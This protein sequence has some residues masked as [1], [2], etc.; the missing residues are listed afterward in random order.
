[1]TAHRSSNG[2][3]WRGLPASAQAYVA[4]VIG[5]GALAVAASVPFR[6]DHPILFASLL[7]ASCLTSVWKVN[8][9]IPLASGSTLSVSYAANLTALLLLG[10]QQ[11][12]IIAIVG[13]WVQC[14]FNVKC[15]YPPYR[16]AFSVAAEAITMCLTAAAYAW[17][18]GTLA[19]NGFSHLS[20]PVVAAIATYFVVNT[21]LVANAIALSTRRSFWTIWHDDFLW[22]GASFAVAGSTG[23]VA[24][25]VMARGDHWEALLA[26]APVYFI[27]RT[28]Q[29]I[30]GRIADE[31][32]HLEETRRL[33]EEAVTALAQARRA[34]QALTDEKGRLAVTLQS[35]ADGV[36]ATDPDGTILLMN[37]AA[38]TMTGWTRGDA[39]GRALE[40]VFRNV[41][42]ET[43]TRCDNSLATL[44]GPS[45]GP[46]VR[47]CS[48]LVARDLAERAI[49]ESVAA[50]RDE[51]GRT[52]GM[53][54]AFRDISASLKVQEQR[55]R[56]N[57]QSALG[58]LAGNIAHD[59]NDILM[60][61][62]G[63][64]SMARTAVDADG[65]AANALVE[66][67]RGCVRARQLTWQLL[68]FS[69]GGIPARTTVTVARALEEAIDIALRGSPIAYTL[70]AA[71]GLWTVHADPTQLVQAFTSVL[72]NALEAM[73]DGGT[74][75]IRA[76]NVV[77]AEQRSDYALRVDAGRYVAVTITDTGVG[78]PREHLGRI[79]DPYFT[80]KH[81]SSGLGLATTHSIVRNH[82]GFVGVDSEAGR[83][84]TIRLDLPASSIEPLTLERRPTKT[85]NRRWRRVLVM[86]DEASVRTMAANMLEFLGYQ[87]EAVESGDAAVERYRRAIDKGSPFDLVLL[88][89]VVPGGMGGKETVD[90][91][92]SIDPSVKA[93]LV[94]GYAQYGVPNNYRDQ[95]F[96]AVITKPFTLQELNSALRTVMAASSYR[97]H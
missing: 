72:A 86:D 92:A 49:E 95:G 59:Y 61:V 7:V 84:T 88:D 43:R 58:V 1:M 19:P 24:A 36:I 6:W 13:V 9:P 63:N 62:M 64:V 89:L 78:I 23:A 48:L 76:E 44:A 29:M 28:Y 52:I 47:R 53:V 87:A 68:N 5:A 50:V 96:G 38:E 80:T 2:L 25:V 94:S 26:F 70:T 71:P 46:G 54:L 79:F 82:G 42:P 41:D 21:G 93:V 56:A 14:T 85:A 66:A 81:R 97:V 4:I 22:S 10:P 69:N 27:Y 37:S 91:L 8:L 90:Q 55:A 60:S 57:K 73:P 17:A 67:E 51:Y 31:R 32:R 16:T 18:G 40:S 35:I 77:E 15:T 33:H 30:V 83:G 74:I 45:A 75:D 65:A 34:E 12:L 20:G 3:G 11:A 39:I